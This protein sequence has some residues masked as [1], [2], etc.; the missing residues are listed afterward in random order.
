MYRIAIILY[1]QVYV[2]EFINCER[3]KNSQFAN[4]HSQLKSVLQIMTAYHFID[5]L[6]R[7]ILVQIIDKLDGLLALVGL[8]GSQL[9]G[10]Q[11]HPHVENRVLRASPSSLVLV[12]VKDL[13][14]DVLSKEL[15]IEQVFDTVPV[16]LRLKQ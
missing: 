13:E 2:C 5:H 15:V 1:A 8:R 11:L 16:N 3:R 12:S 4:R 7:V 6:S 14:L 9:L 10:W